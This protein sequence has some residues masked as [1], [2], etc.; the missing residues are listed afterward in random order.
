V[1]EVPTADQYGVQGDAFSVAVRNGGPVPT[2]PG[3][4]VGN[5]AV[6]EQLLQRRA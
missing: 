1:I 4:G 2:P 5:L 6:I 3:N